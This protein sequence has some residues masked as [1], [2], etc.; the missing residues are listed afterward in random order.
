[1]FLKW[2]RSE[3]EGFENF[4]AHISTKTQVEEEAKP[5]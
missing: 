4:E 2:L 3:L 5:S 1:M